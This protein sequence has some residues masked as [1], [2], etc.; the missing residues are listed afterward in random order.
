M[1]FG[2]QLETP[3]SNL[4]RVE[5]LTVAFS[6]FCSQV[7]VKLFSIVIWLTNKVFT[8]RPVTSNTQAS[9]RDSTVGTWPSS[10]SSKTSAAIGYQVTSANALAIWGK[11]TN[12]ANITTGTYLVTFK[13]L[14]KDQPKLMNNAHRA[15]NESK[16]RQIFSVLNFHSRI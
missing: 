7:P 15:L 10:R 4:I 8:R 5:E 6:L 16:S 3:P 2:P 12:K 14:G 11:V 9:G 1:T 13:R